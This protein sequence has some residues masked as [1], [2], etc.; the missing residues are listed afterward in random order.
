[1][2]NEDKFIIKMFAFVLFAVILTASVTYAYFELEVEGNEEVSTISVGG[3][4][5]SITYVGTETITA[6]NVIPG[7]SAKKYFN[8]T[9]NNQV[10]I[11][12]TFDVVLVIDKS[13][14][15][16]GG[17]GSNS[18]LN[19]IMYKCSSSSDKICSQL[20][21]RTVW[22]QSG[23]ITQQRITTTTNGTDYYAFELYFPDTG[24][25][26]KQTGIDGEVLTFQGHIEIVATGEVFVNDT[27]FATDSWAT[28]KS[29]IESGNTSR[30]NV[31]E[32]KEVAIDGFTNSEPG[33]N[34][35]YTV[36]VANNSH[37]DSDCKD[38]QGNTLGSKQH[39][40]L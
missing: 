13:N 28:I 11:P 27:P 32:T 26:Q 10:N 22:K 19:S 2:R 21:G 34:G 14:F 3:A 25:E 12:I 17:G 30:Y 4:Q 23:K 7:W 24:V 36:R 29:N 16:T 9:S 6:E 40:D 35:L 18:Y 31:G 20:S 15:N 5:L 1:M 37:Y 39:V 38:E 8:I 33:S